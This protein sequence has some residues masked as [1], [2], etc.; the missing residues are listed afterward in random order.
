MIGPAAVCLVKYAGI[1]LQRRHE[2][3]TLSTSLSYCDGKPQATGVFPPQMAVMLSFYSFFVVDFILTFW[4]G[5]SVNSSPLNVRDVTVMAIL[6]CTSYVY[7]PFSISWRK[8]WE[9][10]LR[11][12]GNKLH[13]CG[14][15][16]RCLLFVVSIHVS[17]VSANGKRCCVSV[18]VWP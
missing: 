5:W 8:S 17:T 14:V 7:K 3:E 15:W 6:S 4:T 12:S 18:F 1:M 13:K 11:R 2:M 16:T 10:S 9:Y